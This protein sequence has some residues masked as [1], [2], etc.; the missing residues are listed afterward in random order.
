VLG[1]VSVV[2]TYIYRSR[3]KLAKNNVVVDYYIGKCKN[4][5][6][7]KVIDY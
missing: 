3:R 7:F 1:G 4:Y 6:R 5:I 2:A